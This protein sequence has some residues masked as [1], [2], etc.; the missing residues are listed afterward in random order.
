MKNVYSPEPLAENVTITPNS[1]LN[2]NNHNLRK[3]A[4]SNNVNLDS[5][6]GGEDPLDPMVM[7]LV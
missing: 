2:V 3:Q 4:L 6:S 1:N 7:P 5:D